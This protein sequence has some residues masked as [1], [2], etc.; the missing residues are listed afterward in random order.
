[1]RGIL[2]LIP[3]ALV[4]LTVGCAA[5]QGVQASPRP[6]ITRWTP[7]PE[8]P[9]PE[10]SDVERALAPQIREAAIDDLNLYSDRTIIGISWTI[11]EAL[12]SGL[13]IVELEDGLKR[14]RFND[15]MIAAFVVPSVMALCPEHA[16]R[17]EQP[18]I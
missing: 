6:S 13:T 17:L 2:V 7:A 3:L 16:N 9:L 14:S 18:S 1:M 12:D 4:V 11:C 5:A 15:E 8:T 10:L